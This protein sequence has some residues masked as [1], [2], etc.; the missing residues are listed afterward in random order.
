[1][2]LQNLIFQLQRVKEKMSTEC[3]IRKAE[4]EKIATCCPM[5]LNPYLRSSAFIFRIIKIRFTQRK[6]N[7]KKDIRRIVVLCILIEPNEFGE[8]DE[9]E[10]NPLNTFFCFLYSL[11]HTRV[12]ALLSHTHILDEYDWRNHLHS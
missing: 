9:T 8:V 7:K 11:H 2:I 1:M 5:N 4:A 3:F 10:V 12:Y 6:L